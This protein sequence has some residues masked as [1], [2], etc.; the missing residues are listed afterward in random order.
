MEPRIKDKRWDKGFEEPIR[1][2]WKTRKTF[3]FNQKTRK[4]VFSIDTPPPYVNTPIHVGQAVTY[5]IMDFIARFKRMNGFEVLFPLGL[6][7]N[8]LPIEMAAEKRFGVSIRDTP[9]EKFI[10]LCRRLLE[11]SSLESLDSFYRLG[12][13]YTSWKHGEEIG[14]LYQTDSESYRRTT[15]DTF[16]DLWKKGMI[17][18]AKRVSNYCPECQTTIADAEIEYKDMPTSFVHVRWKVRETGETMI[19]GTTRPELICACAM[20][21]YNPRDKRHRHLRGKHAIL[22]IY[23]R[24]VPIM[25]HPSAKIETGSGLAMMC[26]FGDYTDIRFF[27]EMKLK[28]IIAI[29]MY[30][31]MNEHAGFLEGMKVEEARK[32]MIEALRSQD[33]IEKEQHAMHR[34]PICER[35]KTPIEFISISEYYLRQLGMKQDIVRISD[36]IRF[37]SEKSKQILLDWIDT[38]SMDWAVSRRRYYATE[39][40]L[41]YCRKC[42]ETIVPP[43][44]RYYMPWKEKPPVKKCPKCGGD[45]FRGEERVFDTWFDS[46]ISPLYVLGYARRDGFFRKSMPCSLR[47]QGKEIVRTWL[48]YTLLRSYQLTGK[49]VF[50]NVWIHYHVLDE[51][52]NKMSKSMGNVIDPLD[53]MKRFGAEPFRVWC[54]LEGNITLSDIRC[55]YDR[56]EGTL[57]FLTKLWNI[58]RF[59]SGF[60]PKAAGRPEYMEADRWILREADTIVKEAAEC[61]GSFDFHRPVSEIKHF[62]WETFASH[63]LELVKPRAY[64]HEGVFS[65]GEQAAAVHT[66]NEVLDKILLTLAPVA[67]FITHRLYMELRGKAIEE[68]KFPGPDR[69][70]LAAKTGFTMDEVFELNSR[71]WKAKK[72]KGMSLKTPV[73]YA[74]IPKKFRG[75][76]RD[77]KEAHRIG[78]LEYGDRL[79]IKI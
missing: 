55:S 60:D 41:W 50:G 7:R 25:P 6:D 23:G 10:G 39:I 5:T 48:Y 47:P 17:Y 78:K 42:G 69:K 45:D 71:I 29:N 77:L 62:I 24:E 27:R 79:R 26:S 34:T 72:D 18:N 64:N 54:A 44:G 15:Q 57:K 35:S 1:K 33:L 28:P 14:D 36:R 51:K 67:C 74:S 38:L 20:V 52:G 37:F 49:P 56:I 68:Q 19:I 66:L 3:R 40:P 30:G 43:K 61:Y 21:I 16:I 53:V 46:S 31:S 4:P 58:A 9:R 13:S 59:V 70:N 12:H 76:E 73:R 11:E 2:A 65:R 22:P 32:K 63:Y 75:I 8:G